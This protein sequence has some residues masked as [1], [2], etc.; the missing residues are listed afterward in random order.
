[1]KKLILAALLLPS[2]VMAHTGPELTLASISGQDLTTLALSAPAAK[3]YAPQYC[4]RPST[5]VATTV[6]QACLG[7]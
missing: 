3:V 2:T 4:E 7:Q 1:M 5:D 6:V